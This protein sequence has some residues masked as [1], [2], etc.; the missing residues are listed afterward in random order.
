MR[1]NF[2]SRPWTYPQ[3]VALVGTYDEAGVPDVMNAA[4]VGTGSI[5][6]IILDLTHTHKTVKNLEVTRAF[7][8]T[9]ADS[10]NVVAADYVG[11][12]SG[13]NVP[14]KVA[15]AGWTVTKSE[16]VNAPI[17]N[18]LPLCLE[19][20]FVGFDESGRTIG[21]VVNVNCDEAA[22]DDAG[23]PDAAKIDAIVY[24]PVAHAYFRLGERVGT[25]FADGKALM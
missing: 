23:M 20:E 5:D 16:F 21:R 10:K 18:E 25:A 14:D 2:G 17:V 15:K 9:F 19:C 6:T 1:K 8:V 4:W 7:T 11:I 22:L 3:P 24:E 13:N 12:A